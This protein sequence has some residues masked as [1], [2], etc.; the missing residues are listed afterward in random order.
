V[1]GRGRVE[2]CIVGSRSKVKGLVD[3][4]PDII[5]FVFEY[6]TGGAGRFVLQTAQAPFAVFDEG[7]SEDVVRNLPLAS[8]I[9]GTVTTREDMG[10]YIE[11]RNR[12]LTALDELKA[13]AESGD[14][15]R[16]VAARDRFPDEL[17]IAGAI[18][19]I[20]TARNRLSRQAREIRESNLPED[21]KRAALEAIDTRV[22]QLVSRGNQLMRG[23]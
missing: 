21:R 3:V 15:R 4:S 18:R 17:R 8:K 10:D 14:A 13:A 5:E 7:F 6:L 22:Q 19:A 23:L 2:T 1:H 16:I 11:K 20:D 12:V 9:I